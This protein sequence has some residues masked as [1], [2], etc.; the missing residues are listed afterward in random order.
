MP[1][2]KTKEMKKMKQYYKKVISPAQT[3]KKK[4]PGFYQIENATVR[5]PSYD[6]KLTIDMQR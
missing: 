1:V 2:S 6:D 4:E 5:M 3:S